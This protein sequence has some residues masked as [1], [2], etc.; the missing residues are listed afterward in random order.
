MGEKESAIDPEDLVRGFLR[1]GVPQVIA[2]RWNVDSAATAAFMDEFYS[3]LLAGGSLAGVLTGAAGK[4]RS[5]PD[6][7]H[8]Y[9]WAAFTGFGR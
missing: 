1:A 9:Y 2:S 8:P 4:I 5:N 7:S 6:M 3:E